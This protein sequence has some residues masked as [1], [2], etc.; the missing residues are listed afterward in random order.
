MANMAMGGFRWVKARRGLNLEPREERPVASGYATG[1]FRGDLLKKLA[2]GTVAVAGIGD[3]VY[4]VA[5]GAVRF[6]SAGVVIAGNFIPAGTTY[7]GAPSITNPQASI[8][9]CIPVVGQ[10]FEVDVN[11][12]QADITT[13]Q[14]LMNNNANVALGAGGSTSTGRSTYVLDST[15]AGTTAALQFRMLEISTQPM[16]DVTAANWKVIGEFNVGQE[17]SPTTA[18]GQ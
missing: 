14:G 5:D 18:T 10:F 4:A 1:I 11:T 13:A 17:P 2:D 9:A 6:K 7:T 8:V 12:G 15:T 3:A 16:N